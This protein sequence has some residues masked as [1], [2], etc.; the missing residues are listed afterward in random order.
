MGLGKTVET[1]AC[2]AGNPPSEDDL[3]NGLQKTLVVA[4]ANAVNQWVDEIF[5]HCEGIIA[6]S[7]KMSD[8]TNQAMRENASI[9]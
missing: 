8:S 9:W 7:Y 1:L 2:I 3:M 6:C 5:K 4:P